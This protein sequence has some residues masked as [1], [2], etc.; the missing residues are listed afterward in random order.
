MGGRTRRGET[1][2]SVDRVVSSLVFHHLPPAVVRATVPEIRRVLRPG[3]SVH[4]LDFGAAGHGAHGL[5]AHVL[6]HQHGDED[7]S[8]E[9]P[10]LLEE[11]GLIEVSVRPF[12][13]TIFGRLHLT[14]GRLPR[15][16]A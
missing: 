14:E 3:G 12:Q 15:E 16:A 7:M 6:S 10:K 1:N 11:A 5:L 13:R 2:G 9:L 8:A 4:V